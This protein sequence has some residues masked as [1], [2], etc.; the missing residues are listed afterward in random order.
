MFW[1]HCV[2]WMLSLRSNNQIIQLLVLPSHYF[3]YW[4]TSLGIMRLFWSALWRDGYLKSSCRQLDLIKFL[5]TYFQACRYAF[6]HI[7]WF[8]FCQ[9]SLVYGSVA[10]TC[11]SQSLLFQPQLNHICFLPALSI[12]YQ[13]CAYLI[14]VKHCHHRVLEPEYRITKKGKK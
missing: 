12:K 8:K 14:T 3:V 10:Q 13:C 1:K 4:V 5:S 7:H 6:D 11:K 9:A 2:R